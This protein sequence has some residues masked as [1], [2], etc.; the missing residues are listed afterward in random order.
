MGSHE[1]HLCEIYVVGIHEKHLYEVYVV[2]LMRST[3]VR[4]MLWVLMGR[5]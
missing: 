5:T 2:V 3:S 4:Y 1:K